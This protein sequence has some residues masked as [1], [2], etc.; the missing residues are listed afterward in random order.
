MDLLESLRKYRNE[1][2]RMIY[3]GLS[4]FDCGVVS[5]LFKR[6]GTRSASLCMYGSF[7]AYT[8]LDLSPLHHR[9]L[10]PA[11]HFG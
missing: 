11:S 3:P 5:K 9:N 1:S 8:V 2:F 6:V 7:L 10:F 4:K